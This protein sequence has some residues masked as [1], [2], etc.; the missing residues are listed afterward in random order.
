MSAFLLIQHSTN[1]FG[2]SSASKLIEVITR[3]CSHV[4][5]VSQGGSS[6]NAF[7]NFKDVVKLCVQFQWGLT[8]TK[9]VFGFI[10]SIMSFWGFSFNL[11]RCW[12][13]LN[14][15]HEFLTTRT[16]VVCFWRLKQFDENSSIWFS[17]V[18]FRQSQNQTIEILVTFLAN[19]YDIAKR[20]NDYLNR[21][22]KMNNGGIVLDILLILLFW[23]YSLHH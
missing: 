23:V 21:D 20:F 17:S 1:L 7:C 13:F 5:P 6:L 16:W 4:H 22:I 10:A 12:N 15:E 3:I 2:I 9:A 11:I 19:I 18:Q 14:R 8:F